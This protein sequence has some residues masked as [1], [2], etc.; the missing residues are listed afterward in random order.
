M[1]Q[2]GFGDSPGLIEY[3]DNTWGLGIHRKFGFENPSLKDGLTL[4][5]V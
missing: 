4:V 5:A 3:G 2:G 1:G